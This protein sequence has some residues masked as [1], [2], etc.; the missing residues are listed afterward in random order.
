MTTDP[1]YPA[2]P[3]TAT[4]ASSSSELPGPTSAPVDA[5]PTDPASM[6]RDLRELESLGVSRLRERYA[7]VFGEPTRSG[8][9]RW[10]VRR[11][12]WRLQA[13]AEGGLSERARQRALE[14]A[15]DE[16]LRVRPP[17]EEAGTGCSSLRLSPHRRVA[18]GSVAASDPRV[19]L[20]GTVLAREHK[21]VI[22]R[23]TVLTSGFEH[24]GK[25]YRSL[26][27][28]AHAITGSHWNGFHFFGLS[29]A[30]AKQGA[31]ARP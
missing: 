31:E 9:R 12:A 25:I 15:R 13:R 7:E 26:S 4:S 3:T 23:V 27:A 8:N 19:P 22:H 6:T 24:E 18:V 11:I 1:H 30:R 16:D 5:D 28:V 20:P 14:L 17:G 21:G 2:R 29:A 10:L